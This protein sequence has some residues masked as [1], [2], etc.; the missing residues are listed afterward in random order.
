LKGPIELV[1]FEATAPA[2]EVRNLV[3]EDIQWREPSA[4]PELNFLPADRELV[5]KLASGAIR[6]GVGDNGPAETA[7]A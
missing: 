6:L 5:E 1:F 3:F 4:M 7:G 2:G